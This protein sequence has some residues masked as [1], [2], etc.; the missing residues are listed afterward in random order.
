MRAEKS[1]GSRIR[2]QS[3]RNEL[4]K[5]D[6]RQ[7]ARLCR[8]FFFCQSHG[9]L[10][11]KSCCAAGC[12]VQEYFV[13]SNITGCNSAA[14]ETPATKSSRGCDIFHARHRAYAF[15]VSVSPVCRAL[16]GYPVGARKK[17]CACLVTYRH[18]GEQQ[19]ENSPGAAR[20]RYR[21]MNLFFAIRENMTAV[22]RIESPH[23]FKTLLLRAKAAARFLRKRSRFCRR[24][25]RIIY[26]AGSIA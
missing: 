16:R 24:N 3:W 17:M 12:T 11:S 20:K 8:A 14:P 19:F 1:R 18:S 5:K 15:R 6:I 25:E 26:V 9:F 7:K 23:R 4:I 2:S 22:R 10:L 21:F 13:P